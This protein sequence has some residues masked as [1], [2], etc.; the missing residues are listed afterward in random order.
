[1]RLKP[2]VT[3][4]PRRDARHFRATAVVRADPFVDA[5][6]LILLRDHRGPRWSAVSRRG[7]DPLASALVSA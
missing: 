4:I 7:W 5:L 3:E 2:F 1:V 6:R